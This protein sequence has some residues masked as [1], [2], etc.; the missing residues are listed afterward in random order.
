MMIEIVGLT[1]SCMKGQETY[2]KFKPKYNKKETLRSI[3]LLG[4]ATSIL[5][6]DSEEEDEEE[7]WVEAMDRS[8]VITVHNQDTLQ[9]IVRTLV[10]LAATTARLNML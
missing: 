6:V 1:I 8:S 2:K 7:E 9:G 5:V 10:P 3:T 4:E